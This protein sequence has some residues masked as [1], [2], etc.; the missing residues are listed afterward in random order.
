MNATPLDGLIKEMY[1]QALNGLIKEMYAARMM[2]VP[3][4]G[5][6]SWQASKH[7][8]MHIAFKKPWLACRRELAAANF[9]SF[10]ER[11]PP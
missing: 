4:L 8:R 10:M 2:A 5:R 7:G 3:V 9:A 11:L 1:V 6:T